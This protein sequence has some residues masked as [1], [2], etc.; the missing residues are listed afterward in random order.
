MVRIL[1]GSALASIPTDSNV[2][3]GRLNSTRV[4]LKISPMVWGF[5]FR[6]RLDWRWENGKHVLVSVK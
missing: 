2:S 4:L 3:G 5:F 1:K 6:K